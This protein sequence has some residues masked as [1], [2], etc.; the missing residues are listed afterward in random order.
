MTMQARIL[1]A[2][3]FVGLWLGTDY[4]CFMLLYLSR[5]GSTA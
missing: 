5:C 3:G 4:R 2:L 1:A